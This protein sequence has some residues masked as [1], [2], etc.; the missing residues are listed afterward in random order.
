[1]DNKHQFSL[2]QQTYILDGYDGKFILR[3]RGNNSKKQ[4]SRFFR[5]SVVGD[6]PADTSKMEIQV[7]DKIRKLPL[8]WRLLKDESY[9]K[10]IEIY[11]FQP[12]NLGDG[13]DI[14]FSCQWP[15]TFTRREDYV[16]YPIH[17]YKRG[18]EKLI[19]KLVLNAVPSYIE[20]IRFDGKTL[21]IESTPPRIS[22][23][24]SKSVVTWEIENPKYI[25]ILQYGRQDL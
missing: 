23:K 25:Y 3:Y 6:S 18:V 19:G 14:E 2:I 15:G 20:G 1:V 16:F 11:F 8:K 10:L 22:K 5:D 21:E 12:L 4:V 13:F 9:E 7:L 24:Q 17:Y